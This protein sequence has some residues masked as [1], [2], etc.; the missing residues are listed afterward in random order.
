MHMGLKYH[1]LHKF[2]SKE[3]PYGLP[4]LTFNPWQTG[5]PVPSSTSPYLCT[6]S[7][8]LRGGGLLNGGGVTHFFVSFVCFFQKNTSITSTPTKEQLHNQNV[9][10]LSH[11]RFLLFVFVF[12]HPAFGIHRKTSQPTGH[13]RWDWATSWSVV[14]HRHRIGL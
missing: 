5:C 2:K 3:N 13:S 7:H 4:S 9:N 8:L 1:V 11:F 6:N 12:K 10:P 14:T